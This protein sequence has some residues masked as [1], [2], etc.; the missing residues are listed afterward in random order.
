L[1]ALAALNT[2][3]HIIQLTQASREAKKKE[4]KRVG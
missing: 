4:K 1:L 3:P 2:K